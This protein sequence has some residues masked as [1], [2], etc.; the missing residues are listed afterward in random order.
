MTGAELTRDNGI[1]LLS[2]AIS[3]TN[4]L[5]SR[6]TFFSSLPGGTSSVPEGAGGSFQVWTLLDLSYQHTRPV[7][8]SIVWA[9][10]STLHLFSLT[11]TCTFRR[12]RVCYETFTDP[13]MA[14]K[15]AHNFCSICVRKYVVSYKPQCPQCLET[16]HEGEL[17]PNRLLKDVMDIFFNDVIPR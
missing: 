15:C 2:N 12:C 16:L 5:C 17:R 4:A 10:S 6:R 11:C 9:S 8:V 3:T 14:S 1:F 13:V 7:I